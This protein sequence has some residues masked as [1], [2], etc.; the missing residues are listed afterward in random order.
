MDLP[1]EITFKKSK[2]VDFGLSFVFQKKM[3]KKNLALFIELY[4]DLLSQ[5]L[6]L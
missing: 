4:I 3:E 1:Y 5:K 2:S 6:K